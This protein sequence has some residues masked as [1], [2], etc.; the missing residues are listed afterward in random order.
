[1]DRFELLKNAYAPA[2]AVLQG[3]GAQL[4]NVH[5]QDDKLFLKASVASENLKNDV[6]NA[7]KSVNPNYD[8][9]TVEIDI[10]PALAPAEQS[11]TV[12][13]GDTLSKIAKQYYGNANEYMKIFNANKDQLDNPDRIQVGQTLKIPA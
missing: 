4:H 12:K 2:L 6:W 13:P 8:D 3:A 11:Y 9:V 7:I 10:N 1:M 5:L